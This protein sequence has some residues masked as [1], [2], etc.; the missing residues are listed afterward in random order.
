MKNSTK[1]WLFL[2]TLSMAHLII[3]YQLADR[4]GLFIGFLMAVALNLLIFSFGETN[5]LGKM[6]AHILEGQD[7]WGV[8]EKVNQFSKHAGVFPAP[9][10]Y[11]LETNTPTALALGHAWRRGAIGVS[12]GLLEKLEHEELHAVIAYLVCYIHRLDSFGFG[13]TS[14]IANSF[15]GLAAAL[16]K[17]FPKVR[18]F[19][20]LLSPLAWLVIRIAVNDKNF[21]DNDDLATSLLHERA[22]LARALWKLQGYADSVPLEIPPCT[23]HLFVVSPRGAYEKNW[24][25][26]AHPK[27]SHR[28]QRL[29]GYYPI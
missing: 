1:V 5:L 24:F 15:M 21:Y 18:P 4:V 16:D 17:P 12:R 23:S 14:I 27:T 2:I 13:V 28:I 25:N 7:P 26:Q 10:I 3:G 8:I 22:W 29:V 9:K 19:T 6:H 11:L 20:W